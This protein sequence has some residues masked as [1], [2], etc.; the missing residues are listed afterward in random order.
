MMPKKHL[1]QCLTMLVVLLKVTS[2]LQNPLNSSLLFHSNFFSK[3]RPFYLLKEI[4]TIFTTFDLFTLATLLHCCQMNFFSFSFFLFLWVR[5]LSVAIGRKFLPNCYR[6]ES[7]VGSRNVNITIFSTVHSVL[8]VFASL[9]GSHFSP[10]EKAC[11][12]VSHPE[13]NYKETRLVWL[14]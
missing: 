9:S 12:F 4:P 5:I 1:D 8:S 7:V 2:S 13:I 14:G 10:P 6:Q 11:P 3:V